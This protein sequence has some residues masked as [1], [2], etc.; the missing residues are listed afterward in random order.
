MK[1]LK[2]TREVE[3][4]NSLKQRYLVQTTGLGFVKDH[5][6]IWADNAD[7]AGEIVESYLSPCEWVLRVSKLHTYGQRV[8]EATKKKGA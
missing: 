5:S 7:Q 1:N 6:E 8:H 4:A 2:Q 3:T